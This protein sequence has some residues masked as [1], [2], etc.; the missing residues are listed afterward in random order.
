MI[1]NGGWLWLWL[2]IVPAPWA[3]RYILKVKLPWEMHALLQGISMLA[4]VVTYGLG[5]Y[6]QVA[7]H[8]IWSGQVTSKKRE[9]G[10][11]IRTYSCNCVTRTINKVTTTTC[12]TCTEPR[13]TVSWDIYSTIGRFNIDSADW[14]SVAVYS[15]PDPNF[16]RDAAKGDPVA[17]RSAYTNLVKGAESS[18]FHDK[19]IKPS[20]RELL[21]EYP[22]K[23]YNY[24]HIDRVLN[25]ASRTPLINDK[26]WNVALSKMMSTLGTDKEANV[27]IVFTNDQDPTFADSL[28]R[29]WL[30][31]KKNDVVIVA[32]VSEDAVIQWA[33]AFSWTL[34]ED[35]KIHLRERLQGVSVSSTGAMLTI[36]DEEI[37]SNF[38][39][40]QLSDFD[41]LKDEISPPLIVV[42]FALIISFLSMFLVIFVHY[43]RNS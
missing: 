11:Y 37:R 8:E 14:S 34:N 41:Y 21:P 25:L 42:I 1:M 39:R 18:L 16:Y 22:T 38:V 23:V 35:L 36:V 33:R 31:G 29:S 13:Y 26:E 30:G 3:I 17:R 28:E 4:F 32:D 9:H 7:D 19:L 40:R 15:L 10:S 43:K 6:G 5:T 20:H 27:V 2:V 12:Q 24:Y